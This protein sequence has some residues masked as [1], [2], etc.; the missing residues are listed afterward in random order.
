MLSLLHAFVNLF[1]MYPGPPYRQPGAVEVMDLL[2]S[3]GSKSQRGI[4]TETGYLSFENVT[5]ST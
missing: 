2:I 5:L 1:M 4:E 3:I